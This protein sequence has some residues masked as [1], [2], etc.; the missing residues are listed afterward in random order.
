M[1]LIVEIDS[2]SLLIPK[3]KGLEK[4]DLNHKNNIASGLHQKAN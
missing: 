4:I 3:N 2:Q 1:N